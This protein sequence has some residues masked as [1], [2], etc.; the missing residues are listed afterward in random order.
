M[1]SSEHPYPVG[2]VAGRATGAPEGARRSS[3]RSDPWIGGRLQCLEV[4][5]AHA[6]HTAIGAAARGVGDDHIGGE[7]QC[8][9]RTGVLER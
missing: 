9:D 2:P 3:V 4:H 7:E 6:A 8:R 1:G 5:A